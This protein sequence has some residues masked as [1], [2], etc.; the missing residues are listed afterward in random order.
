MFSR[1]TVAKTPLKQSGTYREGGKQMYIDKK[2][3]LP[4]PHRHA[5]SLATADWCS[6]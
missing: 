5:A 1:L 3:Y 4:E 2:I 6:L